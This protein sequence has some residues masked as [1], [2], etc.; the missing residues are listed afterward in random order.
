MRVR[1]RL[2]YRTFV[3]DLFS[4][5]HFMSDETADMLNLDL[6]A[7][8]QAKGVLSCRQFLPFAASKL[9]V[10]PHHQQGREC[11]GRDRRYCSTVTA[12]LPGK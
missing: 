7:P 3:L 4:C 9:C 2:S 8:A 11:V 10:K 6:S 5:V 12:L 1:E